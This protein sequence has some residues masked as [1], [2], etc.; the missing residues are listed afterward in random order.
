MISDNTSTSAQSLLGWGDKNLEVGY[1]GLTMVAGDIVIELGSD[2]ITTV[3]P[4]RLDDQLWHHLAVRYSHQ[5]DED[6]FQLFIDG[7]NTP[8]IFPAQITQLATTEN[9]DNQ[10][11]LTLAEAP[12]DDTDFIGAISDLKL[13]DTALSEERIKKLFKDQH[14]QIE[15]NLI[16]HYTLSERAE[17]NQTIEDNTANAIDAS[18]SNPQ[19]FEIYHGAQKHTARQH[20]GLYPASNP[21][22]NQ[23]VLSAAYL[24]DS[25]ASTC[26]DTVDNADATQLTDYIFKI[27]SQEGFFRFVDNGSSIIFHSDTQYPGTS[28][29]QKSLVRA[30]SVSTPPDGEAHCRIDPELV[31]SDLSARACS[32][33]SAYVHLQPSLSYPAFLSD[34]EIAL[35]IDGAVSNKEDNH[36]SFEMIPFDHDAG[37]TATYHHQKQ[38]LEIN[39]ENRALTGAEWQQLLRTIG[40]QNSLQETENPRIVVFSLGAPAF[41]HSDDTISYTR[42]VDRSDNTSFDFSDALEEAEQTLLCSMPGYLATPIGYAEMH[43]LARLSLAEDTDNTRWIRGWLGGADNDTEGDWKWLSGAQEGQIFW[44]GNGANGEPVDTDGQ[45]ASV[46]SRTTHRI[47]FDDPQ[48]NPS[49]PLGQLEPLLDNTSQNIHFTAWGRREGTITYPDNQTASHDYLMMSVD[50]NFRSLWA[51]H[52]A[53]ETCIDSTDENALFTPCGYFLQ[54]AGKDPET[55]PTLAIRRDILLSDQQD[56]CP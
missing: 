23:P 50:S 35:F 12:M 27:A 45:P 5:L 44:K 33:Q 4:T 3:S 54:W 1:F 46:N 26:P 43:A 13:Y 19:L 20:I 22:D 39:A 56:I 28:L 8:L 24:I 48:I 9:S 2:N 40:Y 31:F 49:F 55:E 53:D 52:P 21:L 16:L 15:E 34:T 38:L 30:V 41:F 51:N 25:E 36:T 18:L 17:D 37:L 6:N 32:F 14:A 42:F 10:S 7:E 47:G 11:G 29:K